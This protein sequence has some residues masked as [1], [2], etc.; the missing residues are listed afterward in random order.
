MPKP[1]TVGSEELLGYG[2]RPANFLMLETGL[3]ILSTE[4]AARRQPSANS[5]AG[6]GTGKSTSPGVARGDRL[7]S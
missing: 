6:R 5:I 4:P 3:S 2:L 7:I 1:A